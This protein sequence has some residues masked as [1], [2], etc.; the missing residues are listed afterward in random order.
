[1]WHDGPVTDPRR[2]VRFVAPVWVVLA[3]CS[4]AEQ[5]QAGEN[6]ARDLVTILAILGAWVLAFLVLFAGNV[7]LRLDGRPDRVWGIGA[8][9]F[10]LGISVVLIASALTNARLDEVATLAIAAHLVLFAIGAAN[11][12]RASI[13]EKAGTLPLPTGRP[14]PPGPPP[15]PGTLAPPWP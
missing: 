6:I 12:R 4:A 13:M 15:P 1:V 8:I 3:G 5:A 9:V 11:V 10:G 2:A 7:Y 14:K